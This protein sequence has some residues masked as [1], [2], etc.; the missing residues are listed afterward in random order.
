MGTHPIFESDFDCLTDMD[1]L[2][3]ILCDDS[4]KIDSK[5]ISLR[6]RTEDLLKNVK[7]DTKGDTLKFDEKFSKEVKNKKEKVSNLKRQINDDKSIN[8]I[9]NNILLKRKKAIEN[10]LKKLK[11]V[12]VMAENL[13]SFES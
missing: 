12:L 1:E 10:D 9:K 2:R 13:S 6:N 5:I 8:D 11:E 7:I 4:Q 3:E